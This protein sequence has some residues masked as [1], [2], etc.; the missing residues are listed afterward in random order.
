MPSQSTMDNNAADPVSDFAIA[1][2][3][4][5]AGDAETARKCLRSVSQY[6]AEK[7]KGPA[8]AEEVFKSAEW[9]LL[10]LNRRQ[11]E[12]EVLAK[13][14]GIVN[15]REGYPI[16]SEN[17]N[18]R[19]ILYD[20][21]YEI[22]LKAYVRNAEFE[23][24]FYANINKTF[25][26]NSTRYF[27][28]LPYPVRAK[29]QG[30]ADKSEKSI[31]YSRG[32]EWIAVYIGSGLWLQLFLITVSDFHTMVV[33]PISYFSCEDPPVKLRSELIEIL[34]AYLADPNSLDDA[35]SSIGITDILQRLLN[36]IDQ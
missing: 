16:D 17:K 32:G 14:V 27:K 22:L 4:L 12:Y 35:M 29:P 8:I 13:N 7:D 18:V 1:K 11:K 10:E 33:E 31:G 2:L 3:A 5:W 26:G 6:R 19:G 15:A 30:I 9:M 24:S 28:F 34:A 20:D 23:D 36:L 25:S 21:G